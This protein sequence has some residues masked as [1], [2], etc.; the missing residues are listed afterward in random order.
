LWS[1]RI[2]GI[3]LQDVAAA[4]NSDLDSA[5][6]RPHWKAVVRG[7]PPLRFRPTTTTRAQVR[8]VPSRST[9]Q[10]GWPRFAVPRLT[11]AHRR[12]RSSASPTEGVTLSTGTRP[13]RTG[14][15]ASER[16]IGPVIPVIASPINRDHPI[17]SRRAPFLGW[18]HRRAAVP[19]RESLA[20][21]RRPHRW[22]TVAA[23]HGV[24]L[25][26]I[27]EVGST[28]ISIERTRTLPGVA[29]EDDHRGMA[30]DITVY[31][32][33]QPGE[34][35]RLSQILGD[36]DVNIGGMCAV[37]S[38]GGAAEVHVLVDDLAP[39]LE[40]LEGAGVELAGEQEVIV[41]PLEDRP[42]ALA[43]VARRLG[44]A[45]V[46]ITLAYLA[47]S[48]RLVLATDNF[49]GAVATLRAD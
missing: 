26:D 25:T 9:G 12:G 15:A 32:D 16:L 17:R 21:R 18:A 35:A 31:L 48:T 29:G 28:S 5:L 49:E 36:A 33:D 14:A 22:R 24:P 44:E 38:P 19:V 13:G 27:H 46:N 4:T 45:E 11:P 30:T 8:R 10:S 3:S 6:R 47:T 43:E 20:G 41:V 1:G 34:L 2:G 23:P 40:A 37:T 39:A 7:L 42:G